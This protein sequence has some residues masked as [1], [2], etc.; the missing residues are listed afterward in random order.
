[1]K[2]GSYLIVLTTSIFVM[3]CSTKNNYLN[4]FNSFV[5]KVE[6]N[7][8]VLLEDDWQY[9]DAE[10]KKLSK[11]EYK[12]FSRKLTA[13]DKKAIGKLQARYLTIRIKSAGT[14]LLEEM[15]GGMKYLEG[16]MEGVNEALNN[17]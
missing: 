2:W 3:G 6:A 4:D 14:Q 10:F 12:K 15:E 7:K 9:L 11:E 1:M 17:E 5:T 16:I 8:T 13:E